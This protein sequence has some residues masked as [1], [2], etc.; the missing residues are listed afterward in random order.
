MRKTGWIFVVNNYTEQDEQRLQ[1]IA[2]LLDSHVQYI[3][4]GR[5]RGDAEDTPHLQGYVEFQRPKT[6]LGA[7]R[8]LGLL[9]KHFEPRFGTPEQAANYCRKDGDI[10][11]HGELPTPK[12]SSTQA[13]AERAAEGESLRELAR[14]DPGTFVRISSGLIRLRTALN[15]PS[16][17]TVHT[18]VRWGRPGCGKSYSC[19]VDE[20]TYWLSFKS[21]GIWWDGYDG[22]STIVIDDFSGEWIPYHY[23]KRLLDGYPLMLSVHGGFIAAAYE[24]VIITSNDSPNEWYPWGNRGLDRDSL[25]RRLNVVEEYSTPYVPEE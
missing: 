17:R 1:T 14:S 18:T 12:K 5:E 11:E 15:N 16:R 8:Y 13:M 24:N 21:T 22:Q 7:Q 9:N 25:L 23:L 4:Y 19:P 3:I 6:L 2:E 10:Y 20:D